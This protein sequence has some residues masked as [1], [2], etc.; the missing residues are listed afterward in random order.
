MYICPVLVRRPQEK[1]REHNLILGGL[2]LSNPGSKGVLGANEACVGRVIQ[3]G[4]SKVVEF[5][6]LKSEAHL[7][8]QTV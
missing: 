2:Y 1:I 7:G 6:S 5:Y 3:Q 8:I 4:K